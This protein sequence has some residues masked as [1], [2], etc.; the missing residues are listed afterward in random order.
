MLLAA[1]L[2]IALLGHGRFREL[3]FQAPPNN[4]Y[5]H[6]ALLFGVFFG[7]VMTVADYAQN[8]AAHQPPEHFF[9]SSA[10]LA[11]SLTFE[12]L[13]AGVVEEILFGACS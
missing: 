12:G 6:T 10:N 11:G 9:L 2:C 5:V 13:Y 1:L 8:L 3:G 7:V 4:K